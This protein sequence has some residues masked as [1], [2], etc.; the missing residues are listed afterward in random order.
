MSG[1]IDTS[2]ATQK[3][4]EHD[5]SILPHL[6]R[7]L[8]YSIS[9]L[10]R[11]QHGL[12][13]PTPT[14]KILATFPPSCGPPDNSHPWLAARV[15]LFRGR[16]TQMIVYSSLEAGNTS[17]LIIP[18]TSSGGSSGTPTMGA[19][20]IQS[21]TE[22]NLNDHSNSQP[23]YIVSTFNNLPDS[24]Q[25]LV[26][27]QLVALLSYVKKYLLP[28]YL[29]SLPAGGAEKKEAKTGV[30]LIPAPSP[31]AFLIG[32]LHTALFSLLQNTG[33][34]V[35]SASKAAADGSSSDPVTRLRVHR[36]DDPPYYKFF[37]RRSDFAW[38]EAGSGLPAGYRFLDRCGRRG[39]L[40]S[41]LDLVQSRTHI[42][43]SREQLRLMPGVA[44]YCDSPLQGKGSENRDGDEM[45]IAW[46][47]LGLDGALA[48][49]HV[50]PEHRG[51]GL[52]LALSKEAMRRGLDEEG[53]FGARSGDW[54]HQPELRDAVAGWVHTEVAQYNV[55]SKRV[56]QKIGGEVLSTVMWTVIEVLD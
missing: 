26:R 4:Y 25:D 11:V 17:N 20:A 5:G 41:Q 13:H 44:I 18:V 7:H 42:P 15:D 36:F 45:P 19:N 32:S 30:E 54:I 9:L 43:R 47:F 6:A 31:Q 46:A 48:T 24:T 52:A 3:V 51:K 16:E 29:A 8:P 2:H 21:G 56:M 27:E 23:E 22:I 40:E 49:L 35:F 33:A 55:A 1:T 50:E 12:A 37:F 39:V 38:P 34:N 10:R 14:A 53:V 28:T